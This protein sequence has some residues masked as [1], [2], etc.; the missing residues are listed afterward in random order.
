MRDYWFPFTPAK[1]R[2]DTMH[3]TAEQEGIYFRLTLHYME[4]GGALPDNDIALA[5]IAGVSADVFI[6]SAE[7]VKNFYRKSGEKLTHKRCELILKEQAER[8]KSY[9][10]RK[11][12]KTKKAIEEINSGNND[13]KSG[14]NQND[15]SRNVTVHNSTV[16]KESKPP[17]SPLQGDAHPEGFQTEDLKPPKSP[18]RTRGERLE[19]FMA[20]EFPD[21]PAAC[22]QE[23]GEAAVKAAIDY[24]P[25][26]NTDFTKIV[27]WHFDK[28][29]NHFTSSSKSNASKSDWQRAWQNWWKTEFEKIAKQE[30]RDEFYAQRRA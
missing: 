22:P 5:R 26:T 30:E 16:N 28:F 21:N 15:I 12:G 13:L 9:S 25:N 23:W 14:E 8:K 19:V 3:L 6:K 2:E 27:N 7:V 24:R 1:W 29:F 18:R 20:R 4:T 11:R 10:D 17:V